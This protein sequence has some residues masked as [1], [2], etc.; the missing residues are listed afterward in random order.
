MTE[1]YK[2]LLRLTIEVRRIQIIY[3]KGG[4]FNGR[5]V[6][7]REIIVLE[8][9]KQAERELDTHLKFMLTEIEA[10]KQN[11]TLFEP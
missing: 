5:K 8:A 7:R 11:P 4:M 9:S 3:F 6:P 1:H 10:T 2:T